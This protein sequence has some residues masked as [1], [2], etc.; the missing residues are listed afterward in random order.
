MLN[1]VFRCNGVQID[2]E[3]REGCETCLRRTT[4]PRD[5]DR[6]VMMEPPRIIVFECEMGEWDER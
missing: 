2:G 6:A 5:P 1:D 4:P 3:W